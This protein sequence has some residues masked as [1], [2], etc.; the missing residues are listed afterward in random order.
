M[1]N[2]FLRCTE[3]TSL[4]SAWSISV[5][6]RKL[7][8][9]LNL[10]RIK[11]LIKPYANDKPKNAPGR[12]LMASTPLQSK[13]DWRSVLPPDTESRSEAYKSHP[14]AWARDGLLRTSYRLR[15][16][17]RWAKRSWPGFEK[18]D[19]HQGYL[20]ATDRMRLKS[21]LWLYSRQKFRKVCSRRSIKK[22]WRGRWNRY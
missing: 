17:A 8:T 5:F 9:Q 22:D 15:S 21:T 4:D 1:T 16:I 18:R 11:P 12:S 7:L 6:E 10:G 13:S 20:P 2:D 14:P 3:L 19:Y